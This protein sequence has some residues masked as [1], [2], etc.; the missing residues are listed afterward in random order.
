MNIDKFCHPDVFEI[1]ST[2]LY[3]TQEKFKLFD[4]SFQLI[5]AK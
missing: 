3:L 5:L 1:L 4:K 2:H